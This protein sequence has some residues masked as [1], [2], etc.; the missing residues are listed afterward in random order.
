VTDHRDGRYRGVFSAILFCFRSS[1]FFN[2][3]TDYNTLCEA[4]IKLLFRPYGVAPPIL[5]SRY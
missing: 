5:T 4:K 1:I 2:H 3:E